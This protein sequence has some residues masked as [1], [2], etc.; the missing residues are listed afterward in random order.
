MGIVFIQVL[1]EFY[2]IP[3]FINF[4]TYDLSQ[5]NKIILCLNKYILQTYFALIMY[6]YNN[7][8]VLFYKM[9]AIYLFNAKQ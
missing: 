1:L 7:Y 3:L 4:K 8:H 6:H 5:I 9:A 2:H